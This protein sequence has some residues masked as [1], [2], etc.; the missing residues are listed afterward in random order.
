MT[1]QRLRYDFIA[2]TI[3]S[4]G[5]TGN[6]TLTFSSSTGLGNITVTS[7][8]NYLPLTINPASYGS[9]SNSEVVWVTSYTANAAT[10]IVLRAQEGTSNGGV[11]TG[12]SYTHGPTVLD[13]DVSNL[14]SSGILTLASG[15][16]I[17]GGTFNTS[18]TLVAGTVQA[19]T[20]TGTTL[21]VNSATLNSVIGNTIVNG[22]LTVLGGINATIS[23]TISNAVN[24]S[25]AAIV[26]SGIGSNVSIPTTQLSGTYGAIVVNSGSNITVASGYVQFENSLLNLVWP[27]QA[28]IGYTT[29]NGIDLSVGGNNTLNVQSN[30]IVV[31]G[32][33]QTT[34]SIG[35]N[36]VAVGAGGLNVTGGSNFYN[37]VGHNGYNINSVNT[38]TATTITGTNLGVAGQTTTS[39]LSVIGNTIVSGS[40]TVLGGINATISGTV[41]NASYAGTVVSGIGV[42]VTIPA[43][44]IDGSTATKLVAVTITGTTLNLAGNAIVNS[45]TFTNGLVI[46]NGTAGNK[47][48]F[49]GTFGSINGAY[50]INSM[51]GVFS[52]NIQA[53]NSLTPFPMQTASNSYGATIAS[54]ITTTSA[55]IASISLSLPASGTYLVTGQLVIA[56]NAASTTY[57]ATLWMSTSGTVAGS[58]NNAPIYSQISI[59]GQGFSTVPMI[60]QVTV[61]SATNLTLYGYASTGAGNNMVVIGNSYGLTP[62]TFVATRIV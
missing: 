12:A 3:V 14:T 33:L 56:N 5:G 43:S 37:N 42:G 17:T 2:G 9:S 4:F 39:G 21:N 41:S 48:T 45:G 61:S 1:L 60:G 24:A 27:A 15:L 35:G 34:G 26:V 55:Q 32:N 6:T 25:Y 53:G 30:Q 11:W 19:T 23:G 52:G 18:A 50:S 54:T 22:S 38:I 58:I 40:L 8:V 47:I 51:F 57:G 31:S 62:T 46:G 16:N 59:P 7:G 20:I 13:F 49:N 29:S 10:A 28:S 36:T 44:Q